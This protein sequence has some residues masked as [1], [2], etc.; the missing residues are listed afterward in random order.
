MN[1]Y[2]HLAKA[3]LAQGETFPFTE[4]QI[5]QITALYTRLKSASTSCL[6]FEIMLSALTNRR[7]TEQRSCT[8]VV[9]RR[10]DATRIHRLTDEW[11]P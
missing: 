11:E 7:R 5:D 1:S 4:L 9:A 6:P 8:G 3:R 10:R 2:P